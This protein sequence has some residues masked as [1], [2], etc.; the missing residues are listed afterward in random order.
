MR[1]S[2]IRTLTVLGACLAA[3]FA[4]EQAAAAQPALTDVVFTEYSPL[5]A[6]SE[7]VRRL[8]SPLAAAHLAKLLADSGKVLSERPIDLA[9]EH[10]GLY[11]PTRRPPNGYA[12][13]AF[14]PPWNDARLPPGWAAVLDQ[15]GVIFVSA[16]RSG[17]DQSVLGRRVPLALLA[18]WNVQQRFPV[19]PE[20]VYVAG[21]S[22]GSRVAQ[23][24]ALGYPDLF[25]GAILNAGSNPLGGSEMP[26]PSK[27]LFSRFQSS[28]RI[29]YVT[30]ERDFPHLQEDTAS[31]TSMRRWCAFDVDG[32]VTALTGHAAADAGALS[33]ALD[34]LLAS[35][36]PDPGRLAAC[37][38]ALER[39]L[40]TKIH[41]V[42]SLV[43]NGR[44]D[45]ART[46]L[47]DIDQRFG[48]LG[49][50]RTL[51]LAHELE[52]PSGR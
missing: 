17:N 9:A 46:A 37:R 49:A 28:T 11:V 47:H 22:G 24:L 18:V 52:P 27:G 6:N 36:Q 19:D 35:E 16:A 26:L 32:Q 25:R 14:V 29:V 41:Q 43:T 45:A 3:A 4:V 7:L 42:E 21:F 13:I 38:L 31:T 15:Y 51:E 12:V 44:R 30:G 34:A 39:E 1:R 2:S 10:F 40:A 48:G 5:S 23:R 8:F 33:R 20:R 50:P